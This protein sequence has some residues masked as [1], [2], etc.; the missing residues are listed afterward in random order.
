MRR[1]GGQRVP[2]HT[3][4]FGSWHAGRRSVGALPLHV[5]VAAL[6]LAVGPHAQQQ[7][8]FRSSVE[9]TSLDVGVV[10]R[11]GRPVSDLTPEDFTVQ[12]DGVA[13]RVVSAEWISLVTPAKPAP[14]PPPGYSSNENLTG[15]RLILLVIDQP[16]I[17]FGGAA[18]LRRAVEG[19]IDRL[20][21]SDRIAAVGL[22]PGST[23]TPFTADRARVKQAIARMP[24]SRQTMNVFDF[25]IAISE[26]MAI[27]KGDGYVLERV[28]VRECGAPAADGSFTI[29]QQLCRS[30]AE[31]SA[32]MM[33][34]NGVS[35]T[36]LTISHLRALLTALK[37]IDL[38]KTMVIVTEGFILEDQQGATFELGNLAIEARTSIY[39]MKLDDQMFDMAQRGA[40]TAPFADRLERAQGIEL[41]T[42]A[43][44]GSL[45]N[46]SVNPEAAF[47][48]IESELSG[49]YLLGVEAA[50]ADK[51]GRPHPIRVSVNRSGVNVRSRRQLLTAAG[52]DGPKSPREAAMAAL[53]SPL[54][55]SALPL[56][57]ATFSLRGPDASKIQL[58][59]HAAIG[60][61]YSSSKVVSFGY[62][63]SDQEGRIVESL[64]GDA[65]LP[66]VM[67]GVPSPL[68]YTLA[69]SI[70]PGRYTL[71]LAFA[72]SDRV[73]SIEHEVHA[74]L[75][76]APPVKLSE[77]MVGG[78]SVARRLD[79]PTIGHTVAFGGV[80]GYVEAYGA[81][82][83]NLKARYEVA[84]DA[85]SE[86]LLSAEVTGRPAG[87][88]RTIFSHVLAVRQLPPG[89]YT[90]RATVS[91]EVGEVKR[92]TRSFEIAEPKVLMTSADNSGLST[93]APAEVFLPVTED[94]FTR[95]FRR[96]EA[97]RPD[98]VR[99]FRERV[100][101]DAR[102]AFDGALSSLAAGD[103][104]SAETMLK[105]V[106]PT[107]GD[108]SPV[109]TYLAATFAAAGHDLEA[110]SAWQTALIDGSDFPEIYQWLGDAL[111]R[112]RDLGQARMILEEA[113]AKW[114]SD[115]RFVKPLALLY[116]TFGQ[117]REAVRILDRYLASHQDD[118]PALS[119]G[120][121][122]IYHLHLSGNV[123]R[124]K[125][126]DVKLARSYAARYER[127]KGP[128]LPLVKQW[129]EY[130][131]G[132]RR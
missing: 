124:T 20:Q 31:T 54:V 100:A 119:M 6:I 10:D 36:D 59:V 52:G 105:S 28:L 30:R 69:S 86:P 42:G 95:S 103:Y 68:Q 60:A 99:A 71:R 65:R 21:P 109:L 15:G 117:G 75:V 83:N 72:E 44:R 123:A 18:G 78:P 67:N 26:A 39:A 84:A 40:P 79:Q 130:I 132:R 34:Q 32:Q 49:Y 81:G 48:R 53:A 2:R 51:D 90:L 96:E 37:T 85:E 92:M 63:I 127:A 25:N 56:Q 77:L 121:E 114:P 8:V 102:S 55:V 110:A 43:A 73:G 47:A 129:V 89:T 64:G 4:L 91:S 45:F 131:E 61:D 57:V 106:A 118:V 98:L 22:G 115:E 94:Q 38:P 74:E 66:P 125:A 101:A 19:F 50:A 112:I 126:E 62:V 35:E 93:L 88:E 3:R 12:I 23:S 122:W 29:D 17:R 111:M 107:D 7:P 9:V 5:A 128:Q 108:S 87:P 16:N 80:Q 46:I 113:A 11:D 104:R 97:A 76:D 70:P 14:P 27:R 82:S 1:P 116:A 13:R 58:L 120:V 33:A 41:L 24:G